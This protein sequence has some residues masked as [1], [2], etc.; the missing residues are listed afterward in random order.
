MQKRPTDGVEFL[1]LCDHVMR[2]GSPKFLNFVLTGTAKRWR[3]LGNSVLLRHKK[4]ETRIYTDGEYMHGPPIRILS[5]VTYANGAKL[6]KWRQ[7]KVG[8]LIFFFLPPRIS[9]RVGSFSRLEASSVIIAWLAFDGK[10]QFCF[11][12]TSSSTFTRNMK[13]YKF[14]RRWLSLSI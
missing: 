12:I 11:K 5:P 8:L 13:L 10:L 6:C 7:R 9:S 1:R 2:I 3:W 4:E 14:Y